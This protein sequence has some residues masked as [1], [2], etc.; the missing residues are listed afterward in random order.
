MNAN[1]ID[2]YEV[3]VNYTQ[4]EFTSDPV[5]ADGKPVYGIKHDAEGKLVFNTA[6]L[7]MRKGKYKIILEDYATEVGDDVTITVEKWY[8][9]MECSDEVVKGWEDIVITI[10]SSF[11]DEEVIVTVGYSYNK[12]LKLD[13]EGKKKIRIPTENVDYGR[14]KVT[15]KLSEFPACAE[16]RYVLIKKGKTSLEVPETATVGDIVHLKGT[17]NYGYLAVFVID[18]VYKSDVAI[19]DD[20]FDWYWETSGEFEGGREI[21]VFILNDRP[22]EISI[23]DYVS[24]D[25]QREEGVDAAATIFLF[26]PMLRMTVHKHIA[27]GDDVVISGK[28]TGTDQV[29]IIAIDK[30]GDV[31]FPPDGIARATPVEES[32]WGENIG[33]LDSGNY[34]VISLHK[35]KDG[36]TNAI[37][38]GKWA[39]GGENKTLEERV[40]ILMDAIPSA[41]SDDLFV[42]CNFT[43]EPAYVSFNPIENVTIGEPLEITGKT[44]REPG[45]KIG[46]WTIK[47]PTMLPPVITEVEWLAADQGMFAATIDT[48]DAV[49][50]IYTLKAEDGDLNTDTATVEILVPPPFAPEVS[51]STDKKEYSPSDVIK[52]TIRL[53]NPTDSAQ[54][55]LFE[56]HFIR[57]YNNWTEIEQTTINLSANY[58]QTSTAS[59]PVE[60]WGNKSFC[61]CYIVSLTNMTTNNVVSVD[62][63]SWIYLPS[64]ECK[65]KTSAEIAK[66]IEGVELQS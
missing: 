33:E 8:L 4:R 29:Y 12:S 47:G 6:Q 42:L 5:D 44:N 2:I 41:G 37:E 3:L 54:N 18:E 61:G 22:S 20:K 45:T 48:Y 35:G 62:S 26:P 30:E 52:I 10:Q 46:I 59:I 51:I 23:G 19:I 25:W 43:V 56:W 31:V 55:M 66:G 11:Y 14:Y 40:A 17:S 65:S 16:T 9:E 38:N 7:D 32:K 64:A 63:A 58:D 53:S 1:G 39:A 24:E 49:P 36:R 50:G 21:E 28:A 13:E 15:V 60:D 57:D 34:T 27:A